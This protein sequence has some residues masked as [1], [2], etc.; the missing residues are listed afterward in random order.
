M[1]IE[2]G[3]HTLEV[4][5]CGHLFKLTSSCVHD[6]SS[7]YYA[8]G[9]DSSKIVVWD[10]VKI[11]F[12]NSLIREYFNVVDIGASY[13]AYT[14][15]AKL[16]PK[17]NWF[18]FEPNLKILLTL[19][20]N[21]V[22]NGINNVQLFNFALSNRSGF[23][24]AQIPRDHVGLATLSK[25]VTRFD[26]SLANQNLWAVT[27]LD[28]VFSKSKRIDLIKMDIEGCEYLALKGSRRLLKS[29]RPILFFEAN[30]ESLGNFNSSISKLQ[31]FLQ[32][33]DYRIT[34]DLGGD[35]VA[36]PNA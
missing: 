20:L 10:E 26:P 12:F 2:R 17:T 24:I 25:K 18:A 23:R 29:H 28:K 4:E 16:N 7:L 32:K 34:D 31:S 27:T 36:R 13:G 6:N 22:L 14:M 11:G 33:L 21:I 30:D 35:F 15:L 8:K 5:Y 1:K 3:L 19:N 9:G